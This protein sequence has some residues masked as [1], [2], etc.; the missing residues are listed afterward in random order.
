MGKNE[1]NRE[2]TRQIKK[3]QED[4]NKNGAGKRKNGKNQH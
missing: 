3:E 2:R 1:L 4:T